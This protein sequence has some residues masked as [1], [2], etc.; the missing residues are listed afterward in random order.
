M[1]K[2]FINRDFE[3]YLKNNADQYRMFPSERVW[4]NIHQ[5]LH[6][7]RRW[8]GI[9]LALLLIS[10]AVITSLLFLPSGRPAP[11]ARQTM[12]ATE[13]RF[14]VPES[15][16]RIRPVTS[17]AP[18]T[19]TPRNTVEDR[20]FPATALREE[21]SVAVAASIPASA[22]YTAA[23]LQDNR[24]PVNTVTPGHPEMPSLAAAKKPVVAEKT[25]LADKPAVTRNEPPARTET[26]AAPSAA[27]IAA[28]P[29]K[30]ASLALLTPANL[31]TIESI[32][33]TYRH[34]KARKRLAWHVYATPTITYR[35]LKE[36]K[37]FLTQARQAFNMPNSFS[38]SDINNIVTHKPDLG[39][40]LGVG[41]A[42]PLSRRLRITT[43]LQFNVSKYD[44]RAY[45]HTSEVATIALSTN[46]GGTNSVSTITNY[47]NIGGYRADWLHNLY[48]S[49]SAP[50][51]LELNLAR[52]GRA[53]FGIHGTLQPTYVLGN[54]AY[55][56]SADFKNYAEVPSL[57]RKWNLNTGLEVFAGYNTK[58]MSWRIGPQ[59]R[60]QVFSSFVK[61]YPIS[62]HLF[63]VGI[64]LGVIVK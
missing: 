48:V 54:R 6:S 64:K 51:G 21:T 33:N 55:L 8:Y 4:D 22:T 34:T 11:L 20:L 24:T 17:P 28:A 49:A 19:T 40:Q 53:E 35:K 47:R 23:S 9:G 50:V 42:Y 60:Y 63:D 46:Y 3:Q 2:R 18:V 62:E 43:G 61:Q 37:A 13:T 1:E 52:P 45:T 29:E 32:T 56:L 31:L 14:P 39:I 12:T 36:N 30:P 59:V 41:A 10:T 44:I 5:R 58:K 38:F 57:T 7:R 15:E 16:N 27:P 26:A 25:I